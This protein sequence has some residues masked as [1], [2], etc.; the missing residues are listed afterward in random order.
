MSNEDKLKVLCHYKAYVEL[1]AST[2]DETKIVDSETIRGKTY[3]NKIPNKG[4]Y[5]NLHGIDWLPIKGVIKGLGTESAP[6]IKIEL[7]SRTT[8]DTS[9]YN[10]FI[11][12][13]KRKDTTSSSIITPEEAEKSGLGRLN[14]KWRGTKYPNRIFNKGRCPECNSYMYITQVIAKGALVLG[15]TVLIAVVAG[16]AGILGIVLMCAEPATAVGLFAV[17]VIIIAIG[18]GINKFAPSV[19]EG[20]T[21]D[22]AINKCLDCNYTENTRM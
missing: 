17:Y 22:T 8:E 10:S 6:E 16:I 4:D 12:R 7:Y 11:H 2:Y 5:I 18:A 13:W 1:R 19:V 15:S 21:K 20:V 9:I 14:I 3:L